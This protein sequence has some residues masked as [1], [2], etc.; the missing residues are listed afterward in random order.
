MSFLIL[1]GYLYN[2]PHYFLNPS[3][4]KFSENYSPFGKNSM[5]SIAVTSKG[6]E[7]TNAPPTPEP[8]VRGRCQLRATRLDMM[9]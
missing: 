5:Q 6:S 3:P 2:Y 4:Y 9:R 7:G 1:I 8:G